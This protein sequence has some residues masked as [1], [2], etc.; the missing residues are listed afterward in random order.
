[1]FTNLMGLNNR[2]YKHLSAIITCG[3]VCIVN[4]YVTLLN[5]PIDSLLF[6]F[7]F[8]S[9]F[10]V[11]IYDYTLCFTG[12]PYCIFSYCKFCYYNYISIWP[13]YI[14]IHLIYSDCVMVCLQHAG[15]H[16]SVCLSI[17]SYHARG[18]RFKSWLG[19]NVTFFF[20]EESTSELEYSLIM[21]EVL[22]SNLGLDKF[23]C[24]LPRR[25]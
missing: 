22:G 24:S 3:A 20:Q 6:L 25:E 4:S 19:K 7:I 15:G 12:S 2:K 13:Y 23:T 16:V 5:L 17:L 1:M 18:P 10:F 21:Q 8:F 9:M 14:V 11:L